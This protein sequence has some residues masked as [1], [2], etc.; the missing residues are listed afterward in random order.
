MI[1]L[2]TID[3]C[4]GCGACCRGLST[5][6]GM[7][8]AYCSPQWDGKYLTDHEDYGHWL[9]MPDDVKRTISNYYTGVESGAIEQREDGVDPCFWYD[10]KTKR[11]SYYDDR[12]EACREFEPGSEECLTHP[13]REATP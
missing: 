2:P 10:P 6:P 13:N 12:P 4:R 1:P 8:A 7:Y 3:P 9:R 11:C 5:P